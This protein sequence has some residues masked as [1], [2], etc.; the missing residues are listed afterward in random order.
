LFRGDAIRKIA[1]TLREDRFG[2]EPEITAKTASM[3]CRVYSAPTAPM[4]MQI[5]IFMCAIDYGV[6]L[7]LTG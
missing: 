6:T 4:P 1:P 5:F 3:G 2:F 7:G